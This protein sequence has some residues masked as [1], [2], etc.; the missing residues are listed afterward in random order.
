LQQSFPCPKCGAQ[1]AVG[2]LFC[3][4]CGQ[5]FEYRCRHCGDAVANSSGFCTS[6]GGKLYHHTQRT[7]YRQEAKVEYTV[8][9]PANQF[10][11]YIMVVAI[12]F[13]MVGIIYVVGTGSQGASSNWLG[14]YNFAG[15]SPPSVP[16]VI[17]DNPDS[18]QPSEP[19]SNSSSYTMD[20]VIAAAKQFSPSCRLQTRRTG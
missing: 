16:P 12:I 3:S 10:G 9:Q 5:R 8:Q 19:A 13:F 7:H 11:R 1:I 18:E 17:I 6:C 14:G 2:Q 4:G 15:Q 20:Q